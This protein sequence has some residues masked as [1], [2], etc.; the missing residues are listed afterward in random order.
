MGT[1]LVLFTNMDLRS[2]SPYPLLR[3]GIVSNF[4]SLKKDI[5]T[6]V[7]IIGAG[8]SGALVAWYLHHAGFKVVVLDRRHAA[9]GSTAASTALLQYEIDVPLRELVKKVGEKNA[10]E[11]Y[12]LCRESIYTIGK[13]CHQLRDKTLYR[14]KPSFQFASF[15]KD[16]MPLYE[17]YLIRKKN[18]LSLQ[19]LEPDQI[20]KK[21]GFKKSAGLLSADGAELD[22]YKMTHLMLQKC[23]RGGMEIYDNTGIEKIRHD[24]K[25]VELITAEN[26]KVHA[27]WLVIACG[28]ESQRYIPQQIENLHSTFAI[29]SETFEQK[30]FWYKNS[31]I[32]E[33]ADPYLYIRTTSDNRIIIGG[34]DV[35]FTNPVKR[36]ALI[37]TKARALEKSFAQ[38][39]PSIRFK[40]DFSWTG[41]FGTT[42]DGLPYIGSIP[43]RPNTFFALGFGGNGITFSVIAAEIIRAELLKKNNPYKNIFSFRR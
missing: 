19:W 25:G 42:K 10:I 29:A 36:D 4:S 37:S 17:E 27:R 33:T 12:L 18:G 2:H 8:I 7:A 24:K 38:L 31:L 13:L 39:F 32:W 15:K 22:V 20:E 5:R 26:N 14:E 21:Y 30:D 16:V 40:T 23:K 28:Y 9:M 41:T 1:I 43:Q 6:E 34:K 35:D 3:H 11:S